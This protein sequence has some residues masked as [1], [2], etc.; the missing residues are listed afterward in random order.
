MRI[1]R[2]SLGVVDS[3]LPSPLNDGISDFD[4]DMVVG[5]TS[6]VQLG[7]W[8]DKEAIKYIL[9]KGFKLR[10]FDV[11]DGLCHVGYFQVAFFFY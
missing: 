2:F 11:P 3:V 10:I 9:M 6:M 5:C 7:L 1:Y 4:V 8:F